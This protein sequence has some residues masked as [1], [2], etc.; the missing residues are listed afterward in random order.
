MKYI[1][2]GTAGHVDHGK[3]ALIRALTGTETDRLK[4][5]KERGISIDLGFALLPL[6]EEIMAGVV[7][8]P[9]HERFLK[10][11]LA[12]TGGV[13]LAMLVI[14]ADEGIMPQTR[15]HLAMLSLYGV[16]R[17]VVVINKV[18]KVDAEW[19]ELVEEELDELLA[20][21]FLA[22]APRSRVSAISGEGLA[23]LKETL[24]QEA[25]NVAT[26]DVEAPFR[27]WID[28]VFSIKGH[29]AVVTGSLL[30]GQA[31]VGDL[32]RL[33]PSGAEVRVRGLEWHGQKM[34][35][36][37]AGQ[38]T[39][40]NIAGVESGELA[41]GMVLS[42]PNCGE[43]S[44]V[45]DVM[46]DWQQ[47]VDSGCRVRLHIG[48]AEYIGRLYRF[49]D[50][51]TEFARLVLEEPLTAAFGDRGIL[52]LY[53]PQYLV[54]GVA[55][56]RPGAR[57]SPPSAARQE[58]AKALASDSANELLQ[59]LLRD[60]GEMLTRDELLQ[61]AGYRRAASLQHALEELIGSGEV[62]MLESVYALSS[63]I[64][65]QEEA[66][67]SQLTQF[68]NTEPE[69]SGISKEAL[70]QRLRITEKG[71]DL[72]VARWL[73]N[74]WLKAQSGDLALFDHA[75]KHDAWEEELLKQAEAILDNVGLEDVQEEWLQQQLTISDVRRKAVWSTLLRRGVLIRMGGIHVYS[76][77]I[78]N[79]VNLIQQHFLQNKTLSVAELR[80][81]INTSRKF[82]MP[83]LEYMDMNKYTK[84]DGDTRVKGP[85][86]KD[87]SE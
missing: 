42:A 18:D 28:R 14:A 61:R 11:M 75:Q 32:L 26:R 1:I 23:A 33:D 24:Q 80:D 67:R 31:A 82:A 54:A 59:A 62:M 48:T 21:T 37:V 27:L 22:H 71:M 29:G 73:K 36:I 8:V 34:T 47:E 60:S 3:S 58:L 45:W 10:N 25:M 19:L 79:I 53:S 17:G 77:T 86:L 5:E 51:V 6:G 44:A 35:T 76:K 49:K 52:R 74:G 41:R 50:T 84:R 9:G 16:K 43:C 2:I 20:D 81:M 38:R 40:M 78:Q 63:W 72:L 46:V 65:E 57:K 70:R 7:D 85:K 87:L 12:G 39:A 64:A 83:I 4:E 66:A 55:L 56:V 69:R 13:D 15:E 68:H 30:S